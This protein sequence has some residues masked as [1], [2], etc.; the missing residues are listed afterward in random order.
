MAKSKVV[1]L[2]EAMTHCHDGMT[3]ML[4]GFVNCGVSQT[5]IEG[6]MQAG[7]KD[8]NIL[9]SVAQSC[10]TLCSSMDCS[11]PGFS[12]NGIFQARILE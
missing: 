5:L 10:L 7:I 12:V 2:A 4:P 6:L 3:I 11:L 1:S 9:C 8:L